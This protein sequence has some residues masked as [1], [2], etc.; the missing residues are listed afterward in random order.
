MKNN[1]NY[2]FIVK[3]K[4]KEIERINTHHFK[5]FITHSRSIKWANDTS[6]YLRVSYGKSLDNFGK[7]STFYN[8]GIYQTKNEYAE[9]L[10]AFL[11]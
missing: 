2:T 4:G 8:D 9:A 10:A 11:E 7:I 5:R 1:R 6:V 3:Q